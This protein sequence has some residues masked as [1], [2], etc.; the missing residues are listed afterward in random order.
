MLF[1]HD[2]SCSRKDDSR[3]TSTIHRQLSSSC[4]IDSFYGHERDQ[5]RSLINDECDK[6]S[7]FDSVR[8]ES[9]CHF[10]ALLHDVPD[11]R[12]SNAVFAAM[13]T[14]SRH[15]QQPAEQH[16]DVSIQQAMDMDNRSR[17]NAQDV[18]TQS[19]VPV[20]PSPVH[21]SATPSTEQ[22]VQPPTSMLTVPNILT[23][24]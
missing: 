19:T 12:Q 8:P 15:R 10:L 18:G 3:R 23:N 5:T 17:A 13:T 14:R 24:E 6:V 16:L 21:P 2:L 20:V 11:R 9:T 4:T 1:Y 22:P 7:Q